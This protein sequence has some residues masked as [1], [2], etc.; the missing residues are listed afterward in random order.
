M[1]PTLKIS[2]GSAADMAAVNRTRNHK[3][4]TKAVQASGPNECRLCHLACDLAGGGPVCHAA[5]DFTVCRL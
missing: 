2:M 1:H 5:C 3:A 4:V